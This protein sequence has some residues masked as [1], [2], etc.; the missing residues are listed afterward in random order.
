MPDRKQLLAGNW[1]MHRTVA[2]STALAA[3]LRRLLS[4]QRDCE[5]V[6]APVFTALQPVAKKLEGCHI[7]VAG[8]NCH[9][10][11]QGAFTGEI[12]APMLKEAG[13][14]HVI[15][16][17]SERRALFGDTDELIAKRLRAALTA[18]LLPIVC[19][20]ETLQQREGNQTNAVLEAQLAGS[21]AGI[22]A[23][24]FDGIII[25]YEPVWAIGTGKVASPA[26][27]QE[28]HA[29]VRSALA[30]TFGREHAER[31]RILYGGSVKAD[32]AQELLAC[33]DIDGALVGGASLDAQSFTQI[34]KARRGHS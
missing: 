2:E 12:S 14:S 28:T 11:A 6:V 34:V 16:G 3:E 33:P 9:F 22:N 23:E 15:L 8:Q 31:T 24:E 19:I 5:I 17:H 26:Q 29:F 18:G 4:M 7:A 30:K 21:L 20:G 32:N 1:K 27:A 13:A 10:E 25:A